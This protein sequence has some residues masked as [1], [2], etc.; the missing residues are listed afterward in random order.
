MDHHWTKE[1][2]Y[3]RVRC[4]VKQRN[5]SPENPAFVNEGKCPFCLANAQFEIDESKR[6]RREKEKYQ[7]IEEIKKD[8]LKRKNTLLRYL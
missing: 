6:I 4:E 1:G 5:F 8:N 2:E 3:W 7:R